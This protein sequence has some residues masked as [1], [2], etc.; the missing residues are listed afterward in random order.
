MSDVAITFRFRLR[1]KHSGELSRQAKAVNFVWN[2]CNETSR[3][4]WGLNR[5]WLTGFDLGRL[6]SGS[7][8]MLNLHAHTIQKVCD[9][10]AKS[11]DRA[12][13]ASI[14]WRGRK[15]LGW[16]PFNT[17][18][19]KFDGRSFMFRGVVYEP[20]H[21][22][23]DLKPSAKIGAGTFSSD[24]KGNWYINITAKVACDEPR[25][26]GA[27]GIDL[28]LK[29]MA[30]LSSGEKIPMPGFYRASERNIASA[31]RARKSK[32]VRA[33]HAKVKNRRKDFLHKAANKIVGDFDTIVVGN[34]SPSKLAKTRMA[35]SV[36]DAGWSGF[37]NILSYKAMMHGGRMVEVSEAWT[38]QTCS[39]CGSLPTSRPKG[40]A[41]LGIREWTCDDCGSTHD[42]DVNAARNIL[43]VG[44]DTL[45]EG[46]RT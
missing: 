8:K 13:R 3:E 25:G 38:T 18:H 19:V 30:A 2:Y 35:K 24:S 4:A 45:A 17:G 41:G 27:V 6:T 7:S 9:Q 12:K 37:K 32:R 26:N 42:R 43:R 36:N 40:I 29:D 11:R 21:Q 5:Q 34:V 39:V 20:M 44:L 10:F 46:A 31:Q 22:R 28:G 16:V 33:I 14:R 1:D 15:S 23:D